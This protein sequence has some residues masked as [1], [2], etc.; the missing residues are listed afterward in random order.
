MQDPAVAGQLSHEDLAWAT[1]TYEPRTYEEIF[2]KVAVYRRLGHLPAL[3]FYL[4]GLLTVPIRLNVG[5]IL[6]VR[7]QGASGLISLPDFQRALRAEPALLAEWIAALRLD[8]VASRVQEADELTARL[9]AAGEAA[10][11]HS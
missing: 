1:F 7:T 2:H 6:L 8:I 10:L 4:D 5:K 9:L 11:A 3:L